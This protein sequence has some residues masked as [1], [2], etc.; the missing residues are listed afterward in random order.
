MLLYGILIPSP[1]Y[2]AGPLEGIGAGIAEC[3]ECRRTDAR[4]EAELW[5]ELSHSYS[6]RLSVKTCLK[7]CIVTYSNK[8][9]RTLLE[10][11][12]HS[13]RCRDHLF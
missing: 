3:V 1:S 2:T 11:I 12:N 13:S 10:S 8:C 5:E 4:A 7:P 6:S 9:N